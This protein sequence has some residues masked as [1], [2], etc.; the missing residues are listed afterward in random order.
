MSNGIIDPS[1]LSEEQRKRIIQEYNRAIEY[2]SYHHAPVIPENHIRLS[3][4]SEETNELEWLAHYGAI[5]S[6]LRILFGNEL[7]ETINQKSK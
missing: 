1:I 2:K 4:D 5:I 6:T 7:F 3:Y